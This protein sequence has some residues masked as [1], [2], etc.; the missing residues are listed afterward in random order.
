MYLESFSWPHPCPPILR[1]V[2]KR[3][4]FLSYLKP[5][6]RRLAP[7]PGILVKVKPHMSSPLQL[8]NLAF[9]FLEQKLNQ[10]PTSP[11]SEEWC[12]RKVCSLWFLSFCWGLISPSVKSWFQSVLRGLLGNHRE[13]SNTLLEAQPKLMWGVGMWITTSHH[14][15]LYF[16]LIGFGF[17][18]DT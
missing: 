3:T 9:A 14:S 5:A 11:Q 7:H 2:E 16:C 13:A 17:C 1:L 6:S 15:S 18:F 10:E 8:P 4:C 12:G